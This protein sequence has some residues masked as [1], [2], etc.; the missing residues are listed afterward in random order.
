MAL[1]QRGPL[2][3]ISGKLG[4]IEAAH[5]G[6]RTILKHA[7]S[8]QSSC[9]PLRTQAQTLQTIAMARWQQLS[10]AQRQAWSIAAT[11]RP[12]TDRLGSKHALTGLQ[13]FLTMPHDWRFTS[14][15][16]WQDVPPTNLLPGYL[17]SWLL[18]D[19]D[20]QS[21]YIPNTWK[22][23]PTPIATL[24]ISR[25]KNPN[26]SATAYTWIRIGPFDCPNTYTNISSILT[27]LHV[28]F[29]KY[30]WV[31]VKTQLWAPNY[32]PINVTLNRYKVL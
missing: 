12:V 18:L 32:W 27:T 11:Q 6:G 1:L 3:E 9:S 29:I 24:W 25:F 14:S 22:A 8:R 15:E 5:V 10:S 28:Q 30:E 19:A 17:D 4:G 2:G 26:T 31:C 20:G 7:K 23:A 21:Y 16:H 13:L